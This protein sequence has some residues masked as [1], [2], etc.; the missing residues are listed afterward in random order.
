M[1]TGAL[2]AVWGLGFVSLMGFNFD[3]IMLVIPFIM[4]ARDLSHGIQW[5]GR[6]YD[7]LGRIDN[8]IEACVAAADSMLIPGILAILAN[9]AGIIFLAVGNIPV[10]RQIGIGGAVWM[11]ASVAMVFVFQPILISY[12]P[13]PELRDRG[14]ANSGLIA[15]LAESADRF[16]LLPIHSGS[17]RIALIA[18]AVLAFAV[19]V[20]AER[21]VAVGYQSAGTPIYTEESKINQDTAA[22]SKF[23]PTNIGWIVLETPEYPSSQSGVGT[24][25]LR[26]S[27]D[28]S[29]YLMSRRD[30]VA[31]L[32]FSSLAEKP[33]NM[34]L[35]NGQPKY[36]A[37]PDSDAL[38]ASLW[39]FFFA[40]SAPGEAESYFAIAQSMKNSCIRLLLPD[41][42]YLRLKHLRDDLNNF[43]RDRV[44]T[45]PSLKQVK[46]RYLGGEAGLYLAADDVISR[47]NLLNLA[48]TL[49]AIGLCCAAVFRSVV[50]GALF[51]LLAISLG[52]GLG[53]D[54]GIYM[55]ARI[56][57]EVIGG[58]T[59]N[60]AITRSMRSTGIWVFSTYAVMVGGM[61]AW[62]F[63][64]LLFHSE[65]S[66]LL[67]LLMSTNL[68]AGLLIMPA[69][70]SWIRPPF[71]TRYEGGNLSAQRVGETSG[72]FAAS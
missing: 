47:L 14:S 43:V 22:I 51:V 23:V 2:S 53:V 56:R 58:L 35:H 48:L 54:Y 1:L 21:R 30:V 59:L 15:R 3:P 39:G 6:Y 44:A 50:A 40:A 60:D 7:E 72:T 8:K 5:Q 64:P 4:T 41:H 11:G 38:S 36:Y 68:I 45:D 55:V 33:M 27:D 37:V 25:T 71:I 61:L 26:M 49:V 19:G 9:I 17:A 66:I 46:L 28:L 34:L 65:M 18:L 13:K 10:L 24:D 62:V 70:I 31:V 29:N 63:S 52:I 12:L 69:L 57:D 32:D 16:V 20:A 67:I 42:T